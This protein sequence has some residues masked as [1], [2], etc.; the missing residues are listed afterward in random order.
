[1]DRKK[2][3]DN[4]KRK[5]HI[6]KY[7]AIALLFYCFLGCKGKISLEK[8]K[9]F[10]PKSAIQSA[11]RVY[12]DDLNRDGIDDVL[13]RFKLNDEPI[14][15]EHFSILLGKSDGT[16]EM[17]RKDV[18]SFDK[19]HGMSFDA[20]AITKK[21][22][23]SVMYSGTG[24]CSGS[25]RKITFNYDSDRRGNDYWILNRDEELFQNKIF[26]TTPPKP[27]IV[28]KKDMRGIGGEYFG[29]IKDNLYDGMLRMK[30]KNH[31]PD[32]VSEYRVYS[33]NL[34]RDDFDDIIL[35]FKMKNESENREHFHLF[36]GQKNGTYKLAVRNDFIELDDVDGTAF[37]KIIIKNGYFSL[38]YVGYGN[39]S[40]SYEIITFRYSKN[41]KNWLLHK[42][43]SK[44]VHRYF[45]DGESTESISTRKDFGKIFFKDY[46]GL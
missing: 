16:F 27:I 1:M 12:V 21:G 7:I 10:I 26:T 23:F 8:I 17:A 3:M 13:L 40:G 31:I 44:F 11:I 42:Q 18:F 4:R 30:I 9:E 38:E 25:Y 34:N 15:D 43:G 24:N 35:R 33:G 41:D 28:T 46:R 6:A 5:F 19:K 45:T 2:I 29:N 20:I 22:N 36:L 14:E 39:T 37:D 32:S